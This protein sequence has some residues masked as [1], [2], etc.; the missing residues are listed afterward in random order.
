M[1]QKLHGWNI[2][3]NVKA[4]NILMVSASQPDLEGRRD[5]S[6]VSFGFEASHSRLSNDL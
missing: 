2:L 6:L 5:R 3:S 1:A 4:T